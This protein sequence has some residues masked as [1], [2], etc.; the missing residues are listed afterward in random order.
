M[1]TL[2]V[3]VLMATAARAGSLETAPTTI[4]LS[5]GRTGVFHV[6]NRADYPVTF[7]VEAFDWT[8]ATG[9]DRL[10]PSATLQA[11]PPMAELAPGEKQTVRLRARSGPAGGEQAFRL[12]VSELSG[13]TQAQ[14][15]QVRVLLQFSMPVFAASAQ[16]EPRALTWRAERRGADL[17]LTAVNGGTRRAKLSRLTVTAADQTLPVPGGELAYVLAGASRRWRMPAP[18]PGAVLTV[19][20]GVEDS[21]D[22]LIVTVTPRD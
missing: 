10:E 11:S 15:Q 3:A 12:L 2:L 8:Q 22:L 1:L 20:A 9:E 16:P 14:A 4:E 17:I 18:P 21:A 5:P 13:P 19:K 7:Q 6:V